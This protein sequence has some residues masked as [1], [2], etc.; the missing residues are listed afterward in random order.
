MLTLE[1]VTNLL[2]DFLLRR[3]I[4]LK[5]SELVP[6]PLYLLGVI[7]DSPISFSFT[8]LVLRRTRQHRASVAKGNLPHLFQRLFEFLRFSLGV[9]TT[10][11][12][13][14]LLLL[15]GGELL[16]DFGSGFLHFLEHR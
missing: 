14:D 3:E 7:S 2:Q 12:Q 15:V 6:F 4:I 16:Q 11:L 13:A 1:T 10:F 5:I 8:A 9:L